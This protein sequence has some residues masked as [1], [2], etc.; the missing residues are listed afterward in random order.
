MSRQVGEKILCSLSALFNL[1]AGQGA[2]E[3]GECN[4]QRLAF[5]EKEGCRDEGE[6]EEKHSTQLNIVNVVLP[7]WNELN[8]FIPVPLD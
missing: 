6:R 4:L 8:I 1:T 3:S 7:S 5:T 2:G